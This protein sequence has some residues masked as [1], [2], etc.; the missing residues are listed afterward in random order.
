MVRRHSPVESVNG[1]LDGMI[2]LSK[3]VDTCML[4]EK[5]RDNEVIVNDSLQLSMSEVSRGKTYNINQH[6]CNLCG[7]NFETV[8]ECI[9]HM[10]TE[11]VNIDNIESEIGQGMEELAEAVEC[12]D[13]T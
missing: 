13:A 9:E 11:H 4:V 3:H 10:K 6:Q 1:K 8:K 12:E 5:L 2:F 7:Q